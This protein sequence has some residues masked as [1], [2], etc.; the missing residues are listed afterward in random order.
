MSDYTWAE[1]GKR[2]A[3]ST[4]A[5]DS[6]LLQ[7]VYLF[8]SNANTHRSIWQQKGEYENLVFDKQGNQLAFHANFDTTEATVP[9]FE[10]LYWN[11]LLYTS[12]SPRDQRG[13]RMPSSA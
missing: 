10:L 12:P 13:S 7:G 8:D 9:P 6:T 3:F 1:E 5:N 4:T 11:C 2:L